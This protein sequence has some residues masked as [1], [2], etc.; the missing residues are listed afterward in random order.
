MDYFMLENYYN[1]YTDVGHEYLANVYGVYGGNTL[2][3]DSNG[4]YCF[5]ITSN[6]AVSIAG[7]SVITRTYMVLTI[8]NNQYR[9]FD[10]VKSSGYYGFNEYNSI[11]KADYK[12]FTFYYV[13]GG[14]DTT[15]I[16]GYYADLAIVD[17]ETVCD[18]IGITRVGGEPIIYSYTNSSVTGPST[19]LPGRTV[20]VSAVP[21]ANYGITD[22][23]SQIAVTNNDVPVNFTWDAATNRIVFIMPGS[24]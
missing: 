8:S 4:V 23:T 1:S 18:S 3:T 22:Y 17:F 16:T 21:D 2:S 10:F 12:G 5:K 14:S 19:A 9:L 15:N 11:Y 24:K 7:S 13:I 20:M 6:E